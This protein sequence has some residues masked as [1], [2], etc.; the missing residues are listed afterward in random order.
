MKK[1]DIIMFIASTVLFLLTA[2]CEKP[3]PEPDPEPLPQTPT[4][5]LTSPADGTAV[6]LNEVTEVSFSWEKVKSIN[7]YK[8]MFSL[9]ESMSSPY[10][11]PA[12]TMPVTFTA[13]EMDEIAE[14]LG[15]AAEVETTIC[16]SIIPFSERTPAETQVRS[17]NVT[18]KSAKPSEKGVNDDPHVFKIAVYYEDMYAGD[19]GKSLHELCNWNNPH[20][21]AQQL[22]K[23]MTECSH[24]VIQYEIAVEIEG[25][26]PYAFYYQDSG[27]HTA[28]EVVTADICYTEY[29]KNG[30]YPG[31]GEGVRYDYAKMVT[32]NGFDTMLNDG[33][34]DEVWV[35]NH[36]GAGMY[37]TC[38]AG[39]NAFWING[40]TFE[41]PSLQRKLTVLFCNYERTVDL[42]MHSLA[43]KFE[44]VMKKV[45]GRWEYSASLAKNL[46]N[47]ELFSAYSDKY[48][49]YDS[50][51]SHIG[52]CHFP[53]N[54]ASDYD[55]ENRR[56][57]KS[58][59]DAWD[60]YPD[61][62]FE[63]PRTINSSEWGS[64]QMGYMKW[65]YKHVPHFKGLNENDYHLN[66]WWLYFV[67]YDKAKAKERQLISEL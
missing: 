43:H 54:G 27:S 35:Y 57:V 49:K 66:N 55:Y 61:L 7:N 64:T 48:D 17:M 29:Y 20:T 1:K 44:N 39:P 67:D 10:T 3:A 18:R 24:G 60:S 45:Y 14:E 52:N 11:V 13:D 59:C 62:K 65:F 15:A 33:T 36:P 21:Q 34:I 12:L 37:E 26:V 32:D 22:A 30:K 23:L 50:G 41:V 2:S 6:D 19:T 28:G 63:N 4:I 38:M 46:N 31:I 53:C 16:W 47:W 8:I 5:V 56:Y 40:S 51:C 25:T 9:Q 42:A 58:Y